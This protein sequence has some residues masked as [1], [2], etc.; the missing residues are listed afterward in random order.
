[1]DSNQ[2]INWNSSRL[3]T[4][5]T[6][7]RKQPN[8]QLSSKQKKERSNLQN[9][10]AY[11]PTPII[12]RLSLTLF[13]MVLKPNILNIILTRLGENTNS[14][15][16][17]LDI[18]PGMSLFLVPKIVLYL[19]NATQREPGTAYSLRSQGEKPQP[20]TISNDGLNTVQIRKRRKWLFLISPMGAFFL[21]SST[22]HYADIWA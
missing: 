20:L 6:K 7:R 16:S 8:R 12:P 13:Q 21:I 1:M 22:R 17:R 10:S 15:C 14:K 18:E 4:R 5:I 2:G 19:R 9:M 3:S 11:R